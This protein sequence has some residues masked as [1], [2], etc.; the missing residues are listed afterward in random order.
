MPEHIKESALSA[1][2]IKTLQACSWEYWCKYKLK[3]PDRSNDGASRGT[4]CHNVFE[5]LGNPR[6]KKHYDVI[7]E[8]QDINA[9]K[10]VAKYIEIMATKLNVADQEN[11]KLIHKM[12]L[13]GINCDFFGKFEGEPDEGISEKAFDIFVDED[14]K[15]YRIKGFIDKLFLYKKKSKAIIRDFKSSKAVFKG[16]EL[17]DN[18][19]DLM[20][21][22]AVKKLY[23]DILK[24]SSEFLF[25]KFDLNRDLTG[26]VGKGYV[27][28]KE[29]SDEVLSG[30]EYEL[31]EIFDYMNKFEEADAHSNFASRAGFPSDGTFGGKLKCGKDGPKISRG[32]PVLDENGQEIPAFICPFRKPFDYYALIN[33]DG[34]IIKSYFSEEEAGEVKEGFSLIKKHYEG[35]PEW[36]FNK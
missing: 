21:S 27:E 15:K 11:M 29:I 7:V 4:V 36:N 30:F 2:R 9:S 14:G 22:L 32:Q 17:T 3:L 10:A 25:L 19:Q 1:S 31:T 8:G 35:C 26:E 13:N 16:K 5:C 23:P 33:S 12:T 34:E 6:H 20:Y 18:L 28:M 24:R